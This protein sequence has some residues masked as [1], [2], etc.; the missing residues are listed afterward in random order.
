MTICADEHACR[1]G[2]RTALDRNIFSCVK[3]GEITLNNAGK[4]VDK[5]WRELPEKYA[6]V[7]ID[8]YKI[9]PN[10]L[11]GIIMI[12]GNDKNGDVGAGFPRPDNG[13]GRGNRAPTCDMRPHATCDTVSKMEILY[14]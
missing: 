1:G 10:H 8:E 6:T 7:E 9:M 14:E 11:H 3:N 12:V 4:M 2:S 13:K 5:L